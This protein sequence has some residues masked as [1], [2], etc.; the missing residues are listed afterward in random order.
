MSAA[1]VNSSYYVQCSYGISMEVYGRLG[2]GPSTPTNQ[3]VT[4]RKTLLEKGLLKYVFLSVGCT[5]LLDP[6]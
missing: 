6:S 4:M 2:T 5:L 3:N 1:D